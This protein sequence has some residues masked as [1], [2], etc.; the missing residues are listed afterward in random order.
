MPNLESME[1]C[2]SLED[3]ECMYYEF[4]DVT[5][6]CPEYCSKYAYTGKLYYKVKTFPNYENWISFRYKFPT[7]YIDVQEEYLVIDEPGF[8]GSIGG[9]LGLFIGFSFRDLI[10]AFIDYLEVLC[11]RFKRQ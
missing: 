10:F 3:Y 5:V 11:S 1:L 9:T 2:E 7:E 4:Y 8:I 6:G